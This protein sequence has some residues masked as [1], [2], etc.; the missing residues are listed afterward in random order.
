VGDKRKKPR[1]RDK[2]GLAILSSFFFFFCFTLCARA[3][4]MTWS[5]SFH[6]LTPI[7]TAIITTP[8]KKTPPP[9]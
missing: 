9:T 8:N 4:P 6:T 5:T 3:L 2:N 7:A 1:R